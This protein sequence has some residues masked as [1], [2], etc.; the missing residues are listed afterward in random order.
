MEIR[1]I[2]RINRFIEENISIMIHYNVDVIHF[3]FDDKTY[4]LNLNIICFSEN[5]KFREYRQL[6]KG[7]YM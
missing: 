5:G 6:K 1:V 7:A 3:S 2:Q 4:H